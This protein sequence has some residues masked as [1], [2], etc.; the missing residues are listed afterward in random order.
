MPPRR[1]TA[2]SSEIRPALVSAEAAIDIGNLLIACIDAVERAGAAIRE[3]QT[4]RE[5][6]AKSFEVLLKDPL[7]SRT[8]LTLA[9]QR[10]QAAIVGPLKRDFPG[11]TIVAEED[12]VDGD[13]GSPR[14]RTS[15]PRGLVT[16]ESLRCV[17]LREIC[18][19]VDGLDATREFVRGRLDAVQ[20][21]VGISVRG[22]SV[23][24]V[25][26]LPFHR[27]GRA[28]PIV[29]MV[30]AGVLNLD[31][32]EV[33]GAA[34]GVV[35]AA[36]QD[37]KEDAVRAA[38]G[39][40]DPS[41]VLPLG[42]SGNK[43]LSVATGASQVAVLNLASSLWDTCASEA[44]LVA[45]GGGQ[46]TDIFGNRIN[47][48]PGACTDNS[49]GVVATSPLFSNRDPKNRSH[50][51]LCRQMREQCVA[52]SL[53]ASS[54]GLVPSSPGEVQATDVARDV[55][56]KALT[57]KFLSH[58]LNVTVESYSAPEATAVRYLMSDAVRIRIQYAN[59]RE[60][61]VAPCQS[62]PKSLFYKRIVMQDLDHVRLKLET[63]P[64]KV[65]RDTTSYQVEAAF[66]GSAACSRF[67]A[68]GARIARPYHVVSQPACVGES[69]VYS[70]FAL[71][72][73]DFSP[74]DG[75]SQIGLLSG[76]TL[77]AALT[78]LAEMHAFFWGFTNDKDYDT[79]S[80]AVWN[81]GSYWVPEKQA[82]N[83]FENID[84][85]WRKHRANFAAALDVAGVTGHGAVTLENLGALL[86]KYA[87]RI[88][89]RVH[90]VDCSHRTLIHGD[91]KAANFFFRDLDTA[92]SGPGVGLIDFQ[93]TG[94]GA[95]VVDVAY[96]IASSADISELS[97]DGRAELELLKYYRDQVVHFLA[98]FGKAD[99][100]AMALQLLP[101]EDLRSSYEDA[102]LDLSR[103]VFSYHWARI[104]AS[105]SVLESRKDLLGSNSYNKSVP[106]A[107]WLIAR[108]AALL[109]ARYCTN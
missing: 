90:A 57:A 29:A 44:L 62:R 85:Q 51:E 59:L 34:E 23:A 1:P 80:E 104:D 99:N 97:D 78:S 75:W 89:E 13:S 100:V 47:Y 54:S 35:M 19:W 52:D 87:V 12:Q 65:A 49:Y 42:G 10:A 33:H 101:W 15:C 14:L 79:L 63:A 109:D 36:S 70:K 92:G 31:L 71:L 53:L 76:T 55:H 6:D 7:D 3:V 45:L 5:T 40:I 103:L 21:L 56:G 46:L 9:D 4:S 77:R 11:I 91:A 16:P 37:P 20:T 106:H 58:V 82:S 66:L 93:W 73:E 102:L 38:H 60:I 26:G 27:D 24:G 61:E 98:R 88:A 83:Q 22:R 108:T 96:L 25:I 32:Q 41:T 39:V 68:A 69:P 48:I 8:A 18:I 94:W 86:A 72:L 17:P 67:C 107:M 30:G 43:L 81:Q 84:P 50:K 2:V 95:G 105:P 28:P 74:D 64:E